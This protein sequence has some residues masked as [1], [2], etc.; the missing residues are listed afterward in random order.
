M[1]VPMFEVPWS[2]LGDEQKEDGHTANLKQIAD[3]PAV[4]TE[5]V[6]GTRKEEIAK[7]DLFKVY[8]VHTMLDE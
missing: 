2:L 6:L 1:K 8:S 7:L 4:A 5:E 3:K